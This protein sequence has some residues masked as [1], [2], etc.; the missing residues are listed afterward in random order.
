MMKIFVL[1]VAALLL[2]GCK[3]K[4]AWPVSKKEK[5]A[6]TEDRSTV[7][8]GTEEPSSP[9]EIEDD[10]ALL[11]VELNGFENLPLQTKKVAFHHYVAALA[12]DEI[13]YR[14]LGKR[15]L[16]I[17]RVLEGIFAARGN[18]SEPLRK[19]IEPYMKRFWINHGNHDSWTG[20]KI[21]PLFIP[22]ELA[23]AA[24][25]ALHMGIDLGAEEID[26]VDLGAN[27]IQQLEALLSSF[28]RWMFDRRF[29]PVLVVPNSSEGMDP[30]TLCGADLYGDVTL[31]ELEAIKEHYPLNSRLTKVD[32]RIVEQVYRT[33]RGEV[34]PGLFAFE[35]RAVTG[36][37]TDGL[38]FMS[39][40]E[41]GAMQHLI[42]YFAT[43]E[44]SSFETFEDMWNKDSHP[45]NTKIGFFKNHINPRG[46]KG[47]FGATVTVLDME[48][49]RLMGKVAEHRAYFEQKMPWDKQFKKTEKEFSS[50]FLGAYQTVVATGVSGPVSRENLMPVGL[51]DMR[52]SEPYPVPPSTNVRDAVDQLIAPKT[53]AEFSVDGAIAKRRE[54]CRRESR[55]LFAVLREALGRDSGKI[56]HR[57]AFAPEKY[58]GEY[59][60]PIEQ[61]RLDLI[62]LYQAFDPKTRELGLVRDEEC[63]K[64]LYDD[65]VS[66]MLEQLAYVGDAT[67]LTDPAM[68][69][70]H[71]VVHYAAGQGNVELLET[72]GR[73]AVMVLDYVAL[74]KSFGELLAQVQRIKSVGGSTEAKTLVEEHGTV[75]AAPMRRNIQSRFSKLTLPRGVAFIYPLLAPDFDG[76]GQIRDVKVEYPKDFM[77]RHKRLTPGN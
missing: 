49:V 43:G 23:A 44:A 7:E 38:P 45:V 6:S 30:V 40:S 1:L 67:L 9:Y 60:E 61:M 74:R 5:P 22:G 63:V 8:D 62:A 51:R 25:A 26:V 77:D 53:V 57:L 68:R 54:Q 33:G 18:V 20:R 34:K 65:Y 39:P 10:I 55:T 32:G 11:K 31:S 58:L 21:V 2:L 47:V 3:D 41:Q 16:T 75:I 14:Q 64:A 29:K 46:R 36:H 35:L 66:S 52:L 76:D 59:Y 13:F 73:F 56:S 15:H 24:Q 37:L 42:D 50:G 17:K 19:K 71:A 28:E 48:R 27:R 70:R 69:A 12:G 72:D 4:D